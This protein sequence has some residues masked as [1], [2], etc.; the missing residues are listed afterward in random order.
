MPPLKLLM[1]PIC[2][3]L[4]KLPRKKEAV[5]AKSDASVPALTMLRLDREGKRL[6]AM[7]SL[8]MTVETPMR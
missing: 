7:M 1:E 2:T 8:D 5:H 3:L 4:K 6:P